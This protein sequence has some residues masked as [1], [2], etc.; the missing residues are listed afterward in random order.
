VQY[1]WSSVKKVARDP[2]KPLHFSDK[3]VRGKNQCGTY[4]K[5]PTTNLPIGKA[6]TA[7]V[8]KKT[9]PL[10][11]V[12]SSEHYEHDRLCEWCRFI[13]RFHCAAAQFPFPRVGSDCAWLRRH[14]GSR[15]GDGIH[16][17][18][19]DVP[20]RIEREPGSGREGRS[21]AIGLR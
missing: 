20:G 2:E 16:G 7:G 5:S 9:P 18:D 12:L 6:G 15:F 1:I 4:R 14:G 3:I 10:K 8:I 17:R 19:L 21:K 11:L 13:R